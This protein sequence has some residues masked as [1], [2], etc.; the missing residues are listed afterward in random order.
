MPQLGPKTRPPTPCYACHVLNTTSTIDG[1]D[2]PSA[3]CPAPCDPSM[4][5]R[6][7]ILFCNIIH[8][9]HCSA[10]H[11]RQCWQ[12]HCITYC[13]HQ[14]NCWPS[15]GCTAHCIRPNA[16]LAAASGG[17]YRQPLAAAVLQQARPLTAASGAA[18]R[19]PAPPAAPAPRARC[20]RSAAAT[21]AAPAAAWPAEARRGRAGQG[22]EARGPQCEETETGGSIQIRQFI[23]QQNQHRVAGQQVAA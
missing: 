1:A 4:R 22:G 6:A 5:V 8:D 14:Y 16:A 21:S 3:L 23:W 7:T 19:P 11:K 10:P 18:C 15:C 12:L 2:L 20:S 13:V 17:A 9:V